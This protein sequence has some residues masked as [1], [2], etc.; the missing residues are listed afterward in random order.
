MKSNLYLYKSRKNSFRNREMIPV[1]KNCESKFSCSGLSN[2][3]QP[4]LGFFRA[5]DID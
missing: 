3:E 4:F 1:T 5:H 2:P